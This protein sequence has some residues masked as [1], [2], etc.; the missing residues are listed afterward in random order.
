MITVLFNNGISHP[1]YIPMTAWLW[2]CLFLMRRVKVAPQKW[3]VN[4]VSHYGYYY[5]CFCEAVRQGGLET[6]CFAV[7]TWKGDEHFSMPK[8][9]RLKLVKPC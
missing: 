9:N 2:R 6:R 3:I 8:T 5:F 1:S 4:L 7:D